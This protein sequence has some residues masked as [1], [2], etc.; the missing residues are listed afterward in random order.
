[1]LL[2]REDRGE[3]LQHVPFTEVPGE[4]R[5]VHGDQ[6]EWTDKTRLQDTQ[7]PKCSLLP[8]N[9]GRWQHLVG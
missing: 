5:L 9:S 3:P 7:G 6:E 2:H 1:M 4:W 8:T